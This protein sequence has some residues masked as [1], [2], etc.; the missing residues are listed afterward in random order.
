MQSSKQPGLFGG[1]EKPTR[2]RVKRR[3]LNGAWNAGRT[4]LTTEQQTEAIRL[5]QQGYGFKAIAK[6]FGIP[7]M[8]V[9]R[10]LKKHVEIVPRK[11]NTSP[12]WT[13]RI[14]PEQYLEA[15]HKDDQRQMRIGDETRHWANHPAVAEY[16]YRRKLDLQHKRRRYDPKV[17]FLHNLS[18]G[19]RDML[20]GSKT[21]KARQTQSYVG[22]SNDDLKRHIE[23]Q[24]KGSMSWDN[25]GK[26]HLDH[27]VPKSAFNH[28]DPA[29]VARCWNWQN[30]RPLWAKTNIKK[31]ATIT[32]G[33]VCL[34]L[35]FTK[36]H[37][38]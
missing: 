18:C 33:Q 9:R 37:Y 29:E 24:F 35:R 12:A 28:D 30:L 21:E 26:W 7:K 10:Y 15:I 38:S 27:V 6:Q 5:H 16:A 19:L 13:E 34:P 17:R 4:T 36:S 23:A 1:V 31:N 2:K 3:N 14:E 11:P 25:Y 8:K 22:C 32:D 20:K